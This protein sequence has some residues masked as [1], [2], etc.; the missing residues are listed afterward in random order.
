MGRKSLE[1]KLI[2]VIFKILLSTPIVHPE[3]F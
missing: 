2:M 1:G 3:S